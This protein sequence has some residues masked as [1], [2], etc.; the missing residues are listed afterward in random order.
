MIQI[1]TDKFTSDSKT[2]F[3]PQCV[4]ILYLFLFVKTV[5]EELLFIFKYSICNPECKDFVKHTYAIFSSK[6]YSNIIE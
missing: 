6:Y 2:Y 4:E 5:Y 1:I 3:F